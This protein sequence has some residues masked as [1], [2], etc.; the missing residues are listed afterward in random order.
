MKHIYVILFA[1]VL[2]VSILSCE[3]KSSAEK[4]HDHM[5]E[6]DEDVKDTS[7]DASDA[8]KKET[9]KTTENGGDAH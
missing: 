9:K 4:V 7:N 3:E 8:L 6:A 2:S 5:H 1:S